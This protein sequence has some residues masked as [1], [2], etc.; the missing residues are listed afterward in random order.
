MSAVD[1]ETDA[2]IRQELRKNLGD[3]T[4]ILIAH[5]V[6]TLM[7]ADKI[8]VLDGGKVAQEGTHAELSCQEGIYRR[9]C[10]IQEAIREEET[11]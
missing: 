6:T 5:R 11:A 7:Q 8:I 2:K 1:A 3:A 4:V 10:D 9:I